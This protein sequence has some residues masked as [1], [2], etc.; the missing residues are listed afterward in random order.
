MI[1]TV[2]L[3]S[4]L[5]VLGMLLPWLVLILS[6]VYGYPF[7]D[8]ISATYYIDTCIVPFMIILGSAGMLLISYKG[9]DK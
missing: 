1:N 4:W 9:Y 7:P 3:R 2:R 6:V 5:G 8:S